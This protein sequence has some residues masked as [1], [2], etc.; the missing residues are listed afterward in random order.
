MTTP[1][2][3]HLT[4]AG[5]REVFLPPAH[6]EYATFDLK[7]VKSHSAIKQWILANLAHRFFYNEK[8]QTLDDSQFIVKVLVGFEDPKELSFFMLACPHLM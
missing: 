1:A 6:F 5:V 3:N 4:I 8:Y 7:Q 2:I